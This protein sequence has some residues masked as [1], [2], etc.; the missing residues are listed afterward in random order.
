MISFY[1]V[2]IPLKNVWWFHAHQIK[3]KT[4]W[5]S[6]F[7]LSKYWIS[8][9]SSLLYGIKKGMI[10][11]TFLVCINMEVW[12]A[13]K[14][15][16]IIFHA[17]HFVFNGLQVNIVIFLSSWN[18]MG[19][20]FNIMTSRKAL[21]DTP[22]PSTHSPTHTHTPPH[23]VN[24]LKQISVHWSDSIFSAFTDWLGRRNK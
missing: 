3:Y 7:D 11:T 19:N 1:P 4:I 2:V 15:N 20:I 21:K 13:G 24:L 18:A 8:Y 5:K 23:T 14:W 22:T 6:T 9:K 16:V 10:G 17:Y 12:Q